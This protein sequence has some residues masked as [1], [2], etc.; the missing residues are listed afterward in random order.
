[1]VIQIGRIADTLLFYI[2]RF[3]RQLGTPGIPLFVTRCPGFSVPMGGS[4][5]TVLY[6]NF[7]IVL[8]GMKGS[9]KTFCI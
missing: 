8:H 3:F 5:L 4:S 1:M 2:V 9:S 7:Y 6:S